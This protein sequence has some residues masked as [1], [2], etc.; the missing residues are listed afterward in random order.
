MI[1]SPVAEKQPREVTVHGDVRFDDYAW[2]REKD[3]QSVLHYLKAENE[4]TDSKLKYLSRLRKKLYQEMRSR[5]KEDDNTV[6][7]KYGDYFYYTRTE[8]GKQ[9]DIYYLLYFSIQLTFH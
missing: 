6:P 3:T 7:Y 1:T 8:K 4:Y 9:H 2:L 5:I